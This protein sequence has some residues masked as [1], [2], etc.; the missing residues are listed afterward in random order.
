MSIVS[1]IRAFNWSGAHTVIAVGAYWAG[2]GV[3]DHYPNKLSASQYLQREIL[4]PQFHQKLRQDKPFI[5]SYKIPIHYLSRPIE[6]SAAVPSLQYFDSDF[7][8]Y[9]G[10]TWV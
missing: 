9:G 10:W 5:D 3:A 8:E 1:N 7:S 4:F 6:D 2:R